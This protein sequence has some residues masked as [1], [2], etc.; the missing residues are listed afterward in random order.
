[1]RKLFLPVARRL[2]LCA[3]YPAEVRE[4]LDRIR[5]IRNDFAHHLHAQTFA[6][7]KIRNAVDALQGARVS[8]HF[9]GTSVPAERRKRYFDSVIDLVVRFNL[10]ARHGVRPAAPQYALAYRRYKKP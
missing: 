8:A 3:P 4:E 10:E 9:T 5:N 7:P 6:Y 2:A 1:M